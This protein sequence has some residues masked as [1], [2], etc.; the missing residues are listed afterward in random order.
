VARARKEDF[1]MAEEERAVVAIEI[2]VWTS[3]D[4]GEGPR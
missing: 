3:L 1:V 4:L 2:S